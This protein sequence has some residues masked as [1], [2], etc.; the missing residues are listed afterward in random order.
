ML[1][2]GLTVFKGDLFYSFYTLYCFLYTMSESAG[3]PP[4]PLWDP[5][6]G[7]ET[8]HEDSPKTRTPLYQS[9]LAALD[10]PSCAKPSWVNTVADFTNN[11]RAIHVPPYNDGSAHYVDNKGNLL[12][13]A[14]P[15][16]IE[17]DARYSR[18]GPYFSLDGPQG[19]NVSLLFCYNAS[20]N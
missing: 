20:Q 3:T 1:R 19:M 14:F 10:H 5:Q 18:I 6:A 15:A 4:P 16:V 17:H 9:L 8:E 13:M 11:P 7:S 2:R 12:C